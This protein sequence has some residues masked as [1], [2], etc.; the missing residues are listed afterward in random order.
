MEARTVSEPAEPP[1]RARTSPFLLAL[2]VAVLY[3]SAALPCLSDYGPTWDFVM[4]D[5]PYGERLLEYLHTGDARFLDLKSIEPAPEVRAPHPNF[6]VG[7]FSWFQ[8]T[9]FASLLSAASC[10][11]LWTEL[12]L[13]PA[14][15]AHHLPAPLLAALL[16]FCITAFAARRFGT[17]A[18][19]VAGSSLALNPV[20]FGN[21]CHNLKD[22]AECC[23][24]T[25]AVLAGF[26]ALDGRRTRWWLAAGALA[27]LALVQKP[28][29]LFLPV[30]LG[31][32]LMGAR[33]FLGRA[34]RGAAGAAPPRLELRGLLWATLGFLLA[35]YAVSPPFWTAPLA[36][37]R[38][39]LAQMLKA[40]TG[41]SDL[42]QTRRTTLAVVQLV[43]VTTPPV[44]LVLAG[45]GTLRRSL[46][47]LER[48]FLLLGVLLP[49]AR[50]F[51]PGMRH[52]DGTR[53]FMEYMPML[54]LLTGSG[55]VL[56]LERLRHHLRSGSVSW[57]VCPALLV[58]ASAVP[59]GMQVI[60]THPNQ[61]TYFNAWIGGLGGAQRSGIQ[62][63]GDYWANS[64][65][66][67]LQW[68]GEHAEPGAQLL[69]PLAVHVAQAAAPVRL[70]PDIR[71]LP[72]DEW[73]QPPFYVM[74][75]RRPGFQ[76]GFVNTLER[77]HEPL[78]EI[79]V[80]GG[81]ILRIHRLADEPASARFYKLWRVEFQGR[82]GKRRILAFLRTGG[83][84]ER[85][86]AILDAG[87]GLEETVE[88]LRLLLPPELHE[89][90]EPAVELL[91]KRRRGA[92]QA[93]HLAPE[94]ALGPAPESE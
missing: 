8:I 17:L 28:N 4:G 15:A 91:Q 56:V 52:Y 87:S 9:P 6:E 36:G 48:W 69:V 86:L 81:V 76:R 55:A 71:L 84:L 7:R 27:G 24:Y 63:A 92:R 93:E 72:E 3:L 58:A 59:S 16:V 61:I 45:L 39:V 75:I 73:G 41:K 42:D 35:Y 89:Y 23:L 49:I 67:G 26:I 54:S 22:V 30:Q 64:Y 70:R 10:R 20:F 12:G 43:L 18:G 68:L 83:D 62:D 34:Q 2:L 53:H 80:Q 77:E 38:A 47:P 19:C 94:D 1:A 14:M 37:P 31:L 40:G 5:Y 79:R 13:V 65:W 66:Q 29:A 51:I 82:E 88:E 57:R 50:N 32:F 78:H 85:A 11:L 90:L 46:G 60:A 44:T 25:L 21:A 33:V 74:Y